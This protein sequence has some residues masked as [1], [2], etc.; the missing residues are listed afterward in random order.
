MRVLSP[1]S[2]PFRVAIGKQNVFFFTKVCI[3]IWAAII[4]LDIGIWIRNVVF[5]LQRIE[6]GLCQ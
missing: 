2:M 3:G 4:H 6:E 1:F 5:M